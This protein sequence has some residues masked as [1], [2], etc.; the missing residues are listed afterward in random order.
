MALS[1]MACQA[2]KPKIKPYKIADGE[3]LYLEVTP[4]GTKF[5]RLKYRLHGK[6]KR[7]SI[8]AYPTVSIAD[9]R[10][11]KEEIKKE[12]RVGID[13]VLKRLQAAQTNALNQQLDFKS[14]AMEWYWKQIPLW[15]PKHA[16]IIKH[17]FEKYV[18][19]S[20][21]NFPLADIRPLLMLN[22]LQKIEKQRLIFLV[23]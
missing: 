12:L 17:R 6:E 5:W 4:I 7:I 8:G 23:G 16:D 15:K 20:L 10:K 14:M 11:A 18:F 22:C 1:N 2:A 3:G 9:A 21:G 13:P 19:P